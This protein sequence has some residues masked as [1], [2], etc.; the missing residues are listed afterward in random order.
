M[1]M[2]VINMYTNTICAEARLMSKMRRGWRGTEGVRGEGHVVGFNSKQ[3]GDGP[4]Y[5]TMNL[6]HGCEAYKGE[7]F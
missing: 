3:F 6:S 5:K 1:V 7:L 2:E 4:S